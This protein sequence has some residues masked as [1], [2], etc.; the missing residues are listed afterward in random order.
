VWPG[1]VELVDPDEA[2]ALVAAQKAAGY[3]FLKPYARL[4]RECYEALVI[5]GDEQGLSLMGHVPDSLGLHDV[6]MARQ[7]TIEHMG[8]WADAA[9]PAG[10]PRRGNGFREEQLAWQTVA[11]E[12]LAA[13]AEAV[14]EAEVW[15]C[16]TLIVLQKWSQG[17]DARALLARPEMRYVSPF[18]RAFWSPDSGANYLTQLPAEDVAAARDSV[19]AMQRA[20][21]ML[22]D[23][24]G[25][26]LLGTDMGNPYVVAGFAV[27]EELA[28]LVAAGLT[29]FEALR[30]GTADAARCMGAEDDWGTLAVGRRADLILLE[31]N[32]LA[33]VRN[34]AARVGVAL[35]GRWLPAA[36]LTAELERRARSFEAR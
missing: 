36:E 24:G 3:D 31:A 8:G 14:Q 18:T 2:S 5:A 12:R 34:A 13:L 32:P 33:D 10:A 17:D 21:A 26:L 30:A 19:P 20:V 15:N 23:A 7:H 11:P 28:N 16:P 6:L 25:G 27:H 35:H 1:S 9:Q 29:P 4:T 22:R